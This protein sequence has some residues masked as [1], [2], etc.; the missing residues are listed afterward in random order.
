MFGKPKTYTSIDD[1]P[2]GVFNKI[3]KDGN[4]ERLTIKGKAKAKQLN[5]AWHNIYDEYLRL[6]GIPEQFK[7]YAELK[8]QAGELYAQSLQKGQ[9]WK[10]ALYE[11]KN[12]EA[13]ATIKEGE[14]VEFEKVLAMTS[15]K[16]GFRIDPNTMSVREF[17]G[18]LKLENV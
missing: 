1:C 9:V 15:K 18:Y 11:L 2:I 8:M 10:R 14:S 17:Y 16:S 7:K 3:L 4:L 12:E 13:E 6:Y 5:E